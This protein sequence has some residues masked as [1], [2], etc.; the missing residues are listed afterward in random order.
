MTNF[1]KKNL[2]FFIVL[3]NQYFLP[4]DCSMDLKLFL[5]KWS[6]TSK[7]KF[8]A[9]RSSFGGC[10]HHVIFMVVIGTKMEVACSPSPSRSMRYKLMVAIY[11]LCLLT[12]VMY[13]AIFLISFKFVD[14]EIKI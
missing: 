1:Q 2:L 6:R 3:G 14:I 10:N 8:L 11:C 5:R 7:K 13:V 9:R 12:N 4:L